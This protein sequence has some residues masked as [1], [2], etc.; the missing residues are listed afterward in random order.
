MMASDRDWNVTVR[1][2]IEHV[3]DLD[4]FPE[5]FQRAIVAE[6]GIVLVNFDTPTWPHTTKVVIRVCA[7]RR[8]VAEKMAYDVMLPIFQSVAKT[9]LRDQSFGWSLGVDAVPL[10]RTDS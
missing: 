10:W 7:N 2:R 4:A 8:N 3:T 5:L 1:G 9:I 6:P